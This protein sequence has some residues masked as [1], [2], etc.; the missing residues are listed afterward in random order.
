[1]CEVIGYACAWKVG[2]NDDLAGM[3]RAAYIWRSGECYCWDEDLQ[4]WVPDACPPPASGICEN[5]GTP[6]GDLAANLGDSTTTA[7]IRAQ[8]TRREPGGDRVVEVMV[9][10]AAPQGALAT[11]LDFTVPEGWDVQT[12]SDD[13]LWDEVNRKVKWG[14]LFEDLSRTVTFTAKQT[15]SPKRE[16]TLRGR[17]K[18]HF[19]GFSGTVSFDGVTYAV[20]LR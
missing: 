8:Q 19:E 11:A 17:G 20:V 3:T 4:N 16:G 7:Q 15:Q 13:G 5:D 12:M 2:C 10:I 1:M 9:Q 6:P 14:P 18:I